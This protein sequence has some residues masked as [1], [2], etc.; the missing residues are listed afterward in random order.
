MAAPCQDSAV[1]LL[2]HTGQA[3]ALVPKV[4][5][6]DASSSACGTSSQSSL[7]KVT[8]KESGAADEMFAR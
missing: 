1:R 6:S 4:G 3:K 7:E 8:G 5:R 2:A